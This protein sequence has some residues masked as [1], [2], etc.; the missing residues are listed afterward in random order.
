MPEKA[1]D[2]EVSKQPRRLPIKFKEKKL[3][4]LF[5]LEFCYSLEKLSFK[6]VA[7]IWYT[8]QQVR[9]NEDALEGRDEDRVAERV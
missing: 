7:Q 3:V 6:T 1:F 8:I 5:R 4:S 2:N 9:S